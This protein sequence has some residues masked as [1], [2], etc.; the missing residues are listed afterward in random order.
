M[1]IRKS[2]DAASLMQH[3]NFTVPPFPKDGGAEAIIRWSLHAAASFV[4]PP[5]VDGE[6][7]EFAC[8]DVAKTLRGALADRLCHEAHVPPAHGN[9]DF[10]AGWNPTPARLARDLS[11]SAV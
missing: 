11:D 10:D 6:D 3:P 9:P 8:E 7:E 1:G 5:K 4:S 2:F